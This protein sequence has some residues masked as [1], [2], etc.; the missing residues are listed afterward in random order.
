MASLFINTLPLRITMEP[1]LLTND[2]LRLVHARQAELQDFG[3]SSL[4]HV[5]RW[6]QLPSEVPLFESLLVF[7]NYPIGIS[8][9]TEMTRAIKI[10]HF[11]SIERTHYP[12]TIQIFPRDKMSVRWTYDKSRF[13][14][15]SLRNVAEDFRVSA[16]YHCVS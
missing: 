16:T 12:L 9:T 4:S 5:Q 1:H 3:Y 14:D 10:D 2:W 11:A 13:D 8:N 6:S 7:E 15:A